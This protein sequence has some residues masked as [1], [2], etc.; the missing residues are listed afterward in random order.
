M[1]SSVIFRSV[2]ISWSHG[3]LRSDWNGH[4]SL[5]LCFKPPNEGR[6][7]LE[8]YKILCICYH[9]VHHKCLLFIIPDHE[10]DFTKANCFVQKRRIELCVCTTYVLLF[11]ILFSLQSEEISMSRFLSFF[12]KMR[13]SRKEWNITFT[14]LH[15][16]TMNYWN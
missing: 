12:G 11:S 16:V 2:T 9:D 10:Y 14:S 15:S 4:R 8:S 5:Y 7:K 13:F 1:I 3:N 6:L